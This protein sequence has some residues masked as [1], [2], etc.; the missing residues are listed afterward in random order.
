MICLHF[1]RELLDIPSLN[2][3]IIANKQNHLH[4]TLSFLII[5]ENQFVFLIYNIWRALS[6]IEFDISISSEANNQ[7]I[8]SLRAG[9][10]TTTN[11]FDCRTQ[12]KIATQGKTKRKLTFL[13][14][15]KGNGIFERIF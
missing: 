11:S 7:I 15:Y 13:S 5:S 9:G 8:A 10:S 1:H 12:E 4:R 14:R 2:Q 6:Q 3:A